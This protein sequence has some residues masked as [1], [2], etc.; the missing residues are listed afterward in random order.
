MVL[1]HRNRQ[2]SGW[3]HWTGWIWRQKSASICLRILNYL[4]IL[5]FQRGKLFFEQVLSLNTER[6]IRQELSIKIRFRHDR[7]CNDHRSHYGS[8]SVELLE[9]QMTENVPSPAKPSQARHVQSI[10]DRTLSLQGSSHLLSQVLVS[11]HSSQAML[12]TAWTL[13]Y[14]CTL[15]LGRPISSPRYLG[16][17]FR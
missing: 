10:E 14:Y 12:S 7:A 5:Q 13:I 9:I 1:S 15:S 4:F 17:L 6:L 8:F 2:V 3:C 16:L 11:G